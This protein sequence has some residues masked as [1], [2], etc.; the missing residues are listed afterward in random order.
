MFI[1][2]KQ[3][4]RIRWV[5]LFSALFSS[6]VAKPP[7]EK[8][9]FKN[10]DLV[11]L[12][13]L[14]PT[15]K[16]DI[17]YATS[18]NLAGRPVYTEARAFL[19]RPAAEALSRANK[20]LELLGYR[21]LVFDGYRPWS[22]TKIFW[23]I[24]PATGKQFVAN[25]KKGS[26][27]NR[28]CAVDVSLYEIAS[29]K[30]VAMP[31]EYDEMS[32]RSYASYAGGTPQQRAL[33]DLLRSKMEENGFTGLDAEWWHFDYKDWKSYRIQNIPFSQL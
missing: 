28:G 3:R 14:D 33:R 15:I 31:G 6:C 27:H 17:R 9:T 32:E 20:A 12:I 21:L 29:G 2:P 25:P 7:R 8:G 18:K 4:D 13:K 5:V 1:L 30:E 10:S 23:D 26:R 24:T 16:L 22:V 19:Q 11:E